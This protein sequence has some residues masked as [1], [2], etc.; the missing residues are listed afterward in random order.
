MY[1]H[2]SWDKYN[3]TTTMCLDKVNKAVDAESMFC[4]IKKTYSL[5]QGMVVF[6][7]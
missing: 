2:I 3:S 5:K 7:W 6:L 4:L 1:F